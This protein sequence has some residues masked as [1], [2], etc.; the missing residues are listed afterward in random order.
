[1]RRTVRLI[2]IALVLIAAPLAFAGRPTTAIQNTCGPGLIDVGYGLCSHGPD[3]APPGVDPLQVAPPV[4]DN[5]LTAGAPICIG[6]GSDGPRVQVVYARAIDVASRLSTYRDSFRQWA[7]DA[8]FRVQESAGATGGTRTI[9]YVHDASCVIDVREAVLTTTGDDSFA[10]MVRDLLNTGFGGRADRKWMVFLDSAGWGGC[11]QGSL[12]TDDR[13][14]AGNAHN[15]NGGHGVAFNGCWDILTSMH[16]LMHNLGAV[17]PSAPHAS[18]AYHCTDEFDRMCYDDDAGGPVVMTSVCT[19]QFPADYLLDCNHDDYFHTDPP[20]GNYLATHFN[21]ADSVFLE[22]NN[23]DSTPPST[24][25]ITAPADAATITA[26]SYS[27]TASATDAGSSVTV[28]TFWWCQALACTA[29]G[30]DTTAPFAAT[31]NTGARANGAYTL[32]A[33]ASDATGNRRASAAVAVTLN[34]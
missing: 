24:V 10:N 32:K 33:V 12:Y 2:L 28:V 30:R 13:K 29:F 25:T 22:P 26:T 31:W 1:M 14:I 17:Q 15:V 20:A 3:P 4:D 6:S 27:V 11:G 5:L 9:R 8:N 7:M 16:E 19:P 21:P 18:A 34:H 23:L